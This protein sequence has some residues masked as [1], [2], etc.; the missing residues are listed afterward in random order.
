MNVTDSMFE[1]LAENYQTTTFAIN[2]SKP[3]IIAVNEYNLYCFLGS[4]DYLYPFQALNC[5]INPLLSLLGNFINGLC[6]IILTKSGL[7]KTSNI[8]LFAL[9]LADSMNLFKYLNFGDKIRL[10]GPIKSKPGYC[11]FEYDTTMNQFLYVS[12]QFFFFVGIWGQTISA[13]IPMIITIE[14]IFAVFFPVTFTRIVNIKS[15]TVSCGIA[16]IIWLPFAIFQTFY[17]QLNYIQ[18]SS[19]NKVALVTSTEFFIKNFS[20]LYTLAAYAEEALASWVPICF[21]SLGCVL[22]GIK[23]YVSISHRRKLTNV[24]KKQNWSPRTTRTLVTTCLIF[25]ITHTITALI[26]VFATVD[27]KTPLLTFLIVEISQFFNILCCTSNFL[28]YFLCNDKLSKIFLDLIHARK[29]G[30]V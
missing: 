17:R 13:S 21:I 7:R 12:H 30:I 6:L 10:F 4:Q 29:N 15:V 22:I 23:V 9:V 14:R 25:A 20:I 1:K 5:F 8:L 27:I 18:L 2:T 3:Q 11:T 24:S 19:G 16:Y 26:S 28:V